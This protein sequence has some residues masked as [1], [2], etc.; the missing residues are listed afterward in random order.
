MSITTPMLF[1][2]AVVAWFAAGVIARQ[3][4]GVMTDAQLADYL[5]KLD[6]KD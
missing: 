3:H 6:L 5:A 4:V 2:P 1:V